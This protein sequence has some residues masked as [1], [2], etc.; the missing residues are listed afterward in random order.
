MQLDSALARINPHPKKISLTLEDD[1]P[2]QQGK[3]RLHPTPNLYFEDISTARQVL[4]EYFLNTF[5]LY[6]LLFDCL[7]N[8]EAFYVKPIHLRHPLIFYFGHTAT[9]FIIDIL[10]PLKEGD[11]YC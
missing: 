11:S 6:E 8:E 2:W 5:D 9:F 7:R 3:L 1:S 4:R 10:S